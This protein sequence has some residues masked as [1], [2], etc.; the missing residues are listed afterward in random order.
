MGRSNPGARFSKAPETFRACKATFSSAV[1]KNGEL[2]SPESSCMKRSSVH[3]KNMGKK[4]KKNMCIKQLYDRKVRDFAMALP[5]R[6]LF[7]TFEKWAPSR[8]GL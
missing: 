2:Y 6:K 8:S 7:G 4:K 1:F 5:V 3:I